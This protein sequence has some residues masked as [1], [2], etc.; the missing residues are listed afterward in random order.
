MASPI[1]VAIC[2]V[3]WTRK[4]AIG[5][6]ASAAAKNTTGAG[7]PL[8]CSS[9]TVMGTNTNSQL[10]E[11]RSDSFMA[12]GSYHLTGARLLFEGR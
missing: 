4:L 10:T 5:T 12:R 1:R 9:A 11:G 2:S 6:M 3:A 8:M 7:R